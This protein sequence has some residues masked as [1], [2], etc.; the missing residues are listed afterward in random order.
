VITRRSLI[1][2]RNEARLARRD[3]FPVVMFVFVPLIAVFFMKP[4]FQVALT[5]E[6]VAGGSGAEQV[7]P[8]M[9]ITF[10]FLF[11]TAVSLSFFREHV[12]HTWDRLRAS[13]ATAADIF[14]G[15]TLGAVFLGFVQFGMVFGAGLLLTGLSVQGA[16]I[17]IAAIG[18]AFTVFVVMAGLAIA[19]CCRTLMQANLVAYLTV[20]ILSFLSGALLPHALMPGWAQAAAPATPGYWAMR[21][22]EGAILGESSRFAASFSI[23]VGFAAILLLVALAR[24]RFKSTNVM[25]A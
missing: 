17:E 5:L 4:A 2:A 24:M 8:G 14:L 18:F 21:G 22:Y 11:M 12:W 19:F 20:L 16:W 6:G 23:L 7:V 25:L 9:A 13:P 15:K 3:P 1:I 10:G